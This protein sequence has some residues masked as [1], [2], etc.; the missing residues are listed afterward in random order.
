MTPQ[1]NGT[2]GIN[3]TEKNNGGD[4]IKNRKYLRESEHTKND[5]GL[6]EKEVLHVAG[7]FWLKKT[8]SSRYHVPLSKPSQTKPNQTKPNQTKPNQTKPNQTK[9]LLPGMLKSE[10]TQLAYCRVKGSKIPVAAIFDI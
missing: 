2:D 3:S 4:S 5:V 6:P 7:L 1:I 10:N 9:I 8:T